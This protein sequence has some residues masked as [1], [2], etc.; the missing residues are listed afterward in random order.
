MPLWLTCTSSGPLSQALLHPRNMTTNS[1]HS[2]PWALLRDKS[3]LFCSSL[4]PLG[5]WL[6]YWGFKSFFFWRLFEAE[7]R[8]KEREDRSLC[9]VLVACPELGYS[10]AE[11][12]QC[13]LLS[14]SFLKIAMQLLRITR[15]VK[16]Q[17][18]LGGQVCGHGYAS[19][20]EMEQA[21]RTEQESCSARPCLGVVGYNV[22]C[23][24]KY[25]FY[26]HIHRINHRI[27]GLKETLKNESNPCPNSSTKPL[28]QVPHPICF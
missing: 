4:W 3:Y 26:H 23:N 10:S 24:Q 16:H 14:A 22:R 27:T 18:Q 1:T 19:S 12:S 11:A 17:D 20:L 6:W 28:H 9:A 25:V 13:L 21:S 2:L 5:I 8:F 15:Q 7:R